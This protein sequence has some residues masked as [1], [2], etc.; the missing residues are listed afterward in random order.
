MKIVVLDGYTLNPGDLDWSALESLGEVTIHERT[1]TDEALIV[2]RASGAEVVLTNK[3]VLSAQTIA[4]LPELRYI[5]VL[6]TGFNTVDV[7]AAAE[8][9]IPVT[10]IPTYGTDSVAEMVFAHLLGFARRV[11]AH[12][13]SVAAGDWAKSKDFCYWLSPQIELV[14]KTLGIIGFGRIGR[15]LGELANAFG[16]R[17]LA[18]DIYH[19]N[20]PGWE[21]FAWKEIDALLKESDFVS[22]HCALTP[23][24]TG[25]INEPRLK[26]MKKSAFLFNM[27]RGP[28][29]VD[30]D[31][32]A[33]LHAGEIAGAGIDV[34]EQEP[35]GADNPLYTA[36]NCTITPHIS[37]ATH[38]ARSRLLNTAVANVS[39]FLDGSLQNVVNEVAG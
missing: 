17:V 3:T 34:L 1:G 15:R 24:N 9:G 13:K 32:A 8:R 14:G 19:G 22:L 5:G 28:L 35:P 37:W 27:S 31:L 7:K 2:E 30:A 23:E 33:A 11:D 21:G 39:A 16:M 26:L 18:N 38:E 36:P 6:A 4:S 25:L 12:A 29:V 20:E 10:N